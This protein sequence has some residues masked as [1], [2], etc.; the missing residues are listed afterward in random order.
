MTPA[1]PLAANGGILP[2]PNP[3]IG[4]FIRTPPAG[5]GDDSPHLHVHE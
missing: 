3:T 2:P 5:A 4:A 1:R